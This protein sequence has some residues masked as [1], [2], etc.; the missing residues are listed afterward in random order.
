MKRVLDSEQYYGGTRGSVFRMSS[1]AIYSISAAIFNDAYFAGF[2]E[3]TK[4]LYPYGFAEITLKAMDTDLFRSGK[5]YMW[6]RFR[7]A[8]IELEYIPTGTESLVS[9][10]ILGDMPPQAAYINPPY[11]NMPLLFSYDPT[12]NVLT[13]EQAIAGQGRFYGQGG[14]QNTTLKQ[15][16]LDAAASAMGNNQIKPGSSTKVFKSTINSPRVQIL[17]TAG[18]VSA[19][20]G[21]YVN[22]KTQYSI[23]NQNVNAVVATYG[24]F[25]VIIPRIIVT[26]TQAA[27]PR[28]DVNIVAN[29][30]FE[31]RGQN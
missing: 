27:T 25:N 4:D 14:A 29:F 10:L 26:N 19:L 9:Q 3:G 15:L 5:A 24:T 16:E 18:P 2:P 21:D 7:V 11:A 8:R 23:K 17:A 6:D 28:L 12:T 1:P 22:A 13:K 30:W 31:L 20:S